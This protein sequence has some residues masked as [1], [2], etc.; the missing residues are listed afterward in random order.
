[1]THP[2]ATALLEQPDLGLRFY[3]VI[4]GIPF[5]FLDGATPRGPAG[6]PWTEPVDLHGNTYTAIADALDTDAIPLKD[7]GVLVTRSASDLSPAAMRFLLRDGDDTLLR[8]FGRHRTD[9]DA[10]TLAA[11]LAYGD[12]SMTVESSTGWAANDLLYLGRETMRVTSVPDSTTLD[13]ERGC[14][15]LP[16]SVTQYTLRSGRPTAPRTGASAP[17]VWHGRYVRLVAYVVNTATGVALGDGYELVTPTGTVPGPAYEW[18]AWRGVLT[19]TPRATADWSSWE[20][21]ADGIEAILRTDVGFESMTGSLLRVAALTDSLSANRA[22]AVPT[23]ASAPPPTATGYWVSRDNTRVDVTVTTWASVADYES[24]TSPTV[25]SYTGPNALTVFDVDGQIVSQAD[26]VAAWKAAVSDVLVADTG[27][28]SLVLLFSSRDTTIYLGV[29]TTTARVV[30]EWDKAT[31]FGQLLGR[32]GSMELVAAGSSDV[33][34]IPTSAALAISIPPEATSIP[35]WYDAAGQMQTPPASGF[36]IIGDEATAEVVRYTGI[37]ALA[38]ATHAGVYVMTG[39]SRGM[40]GTQARHIR[41]TVAEQ[42]AASEAVKIRFGVGWAATSLSEILLQ[43]LS[44]GPGDT[45]WND[46]DVLPP[47]V[48]PGLNPSHVDAPA[49]EAMAARLTAW[50]R[51]RTVVLTKSMRLGE[52]A[53]QFLQPLGWWIVGSTG[54]D[55]TYRLRPMQSLPALDSASVLAITERHVVADHAPAMT[56]AG[57]VVNEV[58][59]LYK[60]RPVAHEFDEAGYVSVIDDDSV[61]EFGMRAKLEWKLLGMAGLDSGSAYS[62]V[63]AWAFGVFARFSR[64]Y[65]LVRLHVGRVGWLLSPGDV[66][67]V[68]IAGMPTTYGVR[69]ADRAATVLQVSKAY[70]GD[71]PGAELLLVLEAPDRHTTYSPSARIDAWDGSTGVTLSANEYSNP[72]DKD[73]NHFRAG[74][75]LWVYALDYDFST[76]VTRTI[77]TISGASVTFTDPLPGTFA[78]GPDT[79]IGFASYPECNARQRRFAFFANS[80]PELG[81]SPSEPVLYV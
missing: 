79:L 63:V 31:S 43:L 74:D 12:T 5:V 55:G 61:A 80:T 49:F 75:V 25:Y 81:A 24:D 57:R 35:F 40:M 54:P 7:P 67:T 39:C 73:Y 33:R 65:D 17:R 37:S 11:S 72:P 41:V 6:T 15:G 10:A 20:L 50:E 47:G 1:M 34:S 60:W 27:M 26:L 28:E 29:N 9:V 51:L 2:I 48:T 68:E 4:E 44:S 64:P 78:A 70:S 56:E 32:S 13:V 22:S 52:I 76:K 36:A 14:Y 3:L 53:A 8:L 69:G 21:Q 18:E 71:G 19:A 42:L 77:A 66:V 38:G 30:I 45:S 62:S 59:V 58:K 23:P 46:Y 16:C